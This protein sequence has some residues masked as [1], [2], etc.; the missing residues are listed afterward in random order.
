MT[1]KVT[2]QEERNKG[3]AM[4]IDAVTVF[5]AL[6]YIF[7]AYC[8]NAA[9]VIFGGGRPIDGGRKFIDGKPILG[10]HKTIRGF[11]SGVIVGTLVGWAQEVLAP[12]VGLTRGSV[13]LGLALSLGALTGD[14]LGSF[15]KRRL[16]L[17]PREA[18]PISDQLSFV[19]VAL[20]FSLAVHPP[21]TRY[22]LI[23]LL[24]TPLIHVISNVIAHLLH[25]KRRPW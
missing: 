24:L 14:L 21:P 22:I 4:M 6:Y 19:L 8:A 7:P 17:K 13:I 18:F 23:I 2:V 16:D 9:P 12:Q 20:L 1:I 25:I 5:N 15:I 3:C 11:L 10:S